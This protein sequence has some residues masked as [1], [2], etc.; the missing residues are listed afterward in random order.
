MQISSRFPFISITYPR[1]PSSLAAVVRDEEAVG[2]AGPDL[3]PCRSADGPQFAPLGGCWQVAI[4]AGQTKFT[5]RPPHGPTT[6]N[7]RCEVALHPLNVNDVELPRRRQS[8]TMQLRPGR[9]G[10]E[11]TPRHRPEIAGRLG[12]RVAG[13]CAQLDI[14]GGDVE[15]ELLNARC[16]GNG[17]HVRQAD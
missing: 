4:C 6:G 14:G 7:A 10:E 1:Q 16:A 12:E 2:S 3:T 11:S 8:V 5:H 17:D 15:L 9:V 13:V